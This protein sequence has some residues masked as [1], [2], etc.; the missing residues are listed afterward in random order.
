MRLKAIKEEEKRKEKEI[1]R[2]NE[3]AKEIEENEKRNQMKSEAEQRRLN[4]YRE[5][6]VKNN[7]IKLEKQKIEMRR[8]QIEQFLAEKEKNSF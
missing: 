4:D 6:Q 2:Q 1:K 5:M 3:L 8:T 7:N